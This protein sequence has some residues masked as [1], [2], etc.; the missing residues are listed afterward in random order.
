MAALLFGCSN[1]SDPWDGIMIEVSLMGYDGTA[2][3]VIDIDLGDCETVDLGGETAFSLTTFVPLTLIPKDDDGND[4]RACYAYRLIGSDGFSAHVTRGADDQPWEHMQLGYLMA[5]TQDAEFDASLDLPGMYG[6]HE[7]A[8][9]EIYR[10]VAIVLP[11]TSYIVELAEATQTTVAGDP[12]VAL[13]EFVA[14][15]TTADQYEYTISAVDG[16]S[17][18]LTWAQLQTGALMLDADQLSFDPDLGGSYRISSVVEI[19]GATP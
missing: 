5:E 11:D 1:P 3:Q 16:Y 6:V 10:M 19:E 9:I 18:T 17:R 7:V 12:A 14:G 4:M 15:A 2:E 8:Q 13:T